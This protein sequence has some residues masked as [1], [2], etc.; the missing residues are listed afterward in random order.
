MGNVANPQN[1]VNADP[2][3]D[4]RGFLRGA[5]AG[6]AAGM[7]GPAAA[8]VV[9]AE[10]AAPAVG[11]EGSEFPPEDAELQAR[12]ERY[13]YGVYNGRRDCNALACERKLVRLLVKAHD[14]AERV[15]EKHGRGCDCEICEDAQ[16]AKYNS[17]V[18]AT[19]VDNQL[20]PP[21]IDY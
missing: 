5:V 9:A 11:A 8:V 15:L 3:P 12:R 13:P 4:R 1:P 16:A 21:M 10:P 17:W 7:A 20:C 14:A 2:G 18:V 19:G 6:L